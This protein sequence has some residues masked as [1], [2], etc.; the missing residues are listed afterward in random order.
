MELLLNKKYILW[1]LDFFLKY[2]VYKIE[3]LKKR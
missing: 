3:L 1:K 2:I